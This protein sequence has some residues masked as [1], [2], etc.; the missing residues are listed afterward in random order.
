MP[1]AAEA[2]FAWHDRGGALE[3]L[4]PPWQSVRVAKPGGIRDG[5]E[6]VLRLGPG[7]FALRW[8][9]RHERYDPPRSFTDRQMRGPFGRW[10]HRHGFEP[11]AEGSVLEDRVEYE[12]PLAPLGPRLGSGKAR[13]TLERMFRFRH[14]RTWNDL[15]R[16]ARAAGEPQRIAVTGATGLLGRALCAFLRTGGHEVLRVTRSPREP[17]D[18]RWDPAAKVLDAA[19]LEGCDAVV[20]LAGESLFALRWSDEKKRAILESREQGTRLLAETLARLEKPPRAF[21]SASAV[22]YYG[23]RGDETLDEASGAGSGFL[24]EVCR[25]WEDAAEPA[26][27]AGLRV[28]TLRLGVVLSARGGALATMLPAFRLGAGGRLGGGEQWFPWIALDDAIGA[29]HEAVCGTLEGA[30]NATSPNPVTNAEYTRT[31]ARV[32]R[33]PSLLP[34]PASVMQGLLGEL[35][36]EMLLSS[37]RVLPGALTRAGFPF[38]FPEL[39]SALGFD[40]GRSA[41]PP[42]LEIE[43]G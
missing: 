19:R 38:L 28:A 9:A 22:G 14:A 10:V 18:V 42:G 8:V 7:P 43:H 23:D 5:D 41:G 1:V 32:L 11:A 20:H 37:A 13:R 21:V 31:L 4:L 26:R 34:V 29:I 6:V 24:A 12:L 15:A 2:V 40:L 39:E 36:D 16:H 35:A 17:A 33:R 27:R 30:V 3:R 25:A